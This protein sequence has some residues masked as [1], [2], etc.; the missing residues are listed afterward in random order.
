MAARRLPTGG[1]ALFAFMALAGDVGCSGGPTLVGFV[2][3]SF[4][5]ELKRGLLAA[6]VFPVLIMIGIS[7]LKEKKS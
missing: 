7:R 1:T 5:G 6:I 2:A 3:G 4:N